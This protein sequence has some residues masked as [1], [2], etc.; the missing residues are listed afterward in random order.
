MC[1]FL[2]PSVIVFISSLFAGCRKL[3]TIEIPSSLRKIGSYLFSFSNLTNVI[4]AEYGWSVVTSQ[5]ATTWKDIAV[6]NFS[7]N[8]I[9]LV[10]S[11]NSYYWKKD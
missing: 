9:Y 11:Y 7:S 3:K 2:I 6:D 10:N 4:F 8:A 5:N 1:L